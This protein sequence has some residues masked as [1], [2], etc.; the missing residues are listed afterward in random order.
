MHKCMHARLRG[1]HACT[2]ASRPAGGPPLG[3]NR[4]APDP[5]KQANPEITNKKGQLLSLDLL[6]L[7]SLLL[8]LLLYN[9]LGNRLDSQ[10]GL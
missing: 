3:T 1:P 7:L 6:L 10:Q 5:T 2:C 9:P 8:L 4:K